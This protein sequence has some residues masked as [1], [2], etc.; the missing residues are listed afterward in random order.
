MKY[1]GSELEL[2]RDCLR[3]KTYVGDVVAPFLAG[4]VLEVGAGIGGTTRAL[5]ERGAATSWTALEPDPG[6]FEELEGNLRDVE[7]V[8]PT[9]GTLEEIDAGS[10]FDCIVYV[11]VLEHVE[12]DAAE[13]RR[14]ARR[15]RPGGHLVVVSPAH[16]FLY[17]AFDRAIGHHRRYSP[18]ALAALGPPGLS[19]VR[20]Q[21]LDSVGLMASA[22]NRLLLRQA[23]P[24]RRQLHVWDRWMIPASRLLDPVLRYRVGKSIMVAWRA[25][26]GWA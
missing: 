19:L 17:T 7:I 1:V 5:C 20:R 18:R 12:D 3:W 21:L 14:A 15:L 16:A 24:T 6:L 25:P 23:M 9:L 10:R 11:D 8:E 2:F 4:R 13:L 26:E 22:A